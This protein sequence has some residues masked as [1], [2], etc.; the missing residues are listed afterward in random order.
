MLRLLIHNWW[1]LTLRSLFA[2]SFAA[3]A[4]SMVGLTF[5]PLLIV[6]SFAAVVAFFG[7]LE[8]IT[9]QMVLGHAPRGQPPSSCQV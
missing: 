9:W 3:I 2:L 7:W 1:L 8:F 4:I 6:I 5:S